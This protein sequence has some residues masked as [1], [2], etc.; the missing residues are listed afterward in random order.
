MH[1]HLSL[2]YFLGSPK[3]SVYSSSRYLILCRDFN[4]NSCFHSLEVLSPSERVA[5][6][7]QILIP[8][9]RILP[10]H[11]LTDIFFS[12]FVLEPLEILSLYW[13]LTYACNRIFAIFSPAFLTF[14]G[15]RFLHFLVRHILGTGSDCVYVYVC[16]RACVCMCV[17][18][19]N[20]NGK[21]GED[22][23]L[24][25]SLFLKVCWF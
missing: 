13:N 3:S 18:I 8:D 22:T 5:I 1:C 14:Y 16:A 9:T 21:W 7:T 17:V 23:N 6:M 12:S 19:R 20:I 10:S 2:P 4:S 15:E 11:P 24:N 25:Q